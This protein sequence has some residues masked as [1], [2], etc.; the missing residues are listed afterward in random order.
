M[1]VFKLIKGFENYSVSNLGNVKN[2]IK[3]KILK[4]S[5]SHGYLNVCINGKNKLVHRLVAESFIPNPENKPCV[6][7]INNIRDDN[8]IENLRLATNKENSQN[9]S[10]SSNQELK[11]LIGIKDIIDG[12]QQYLKMG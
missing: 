1:E 11:G 2:N 6:D 4:Q 5:N 12:E 3:N 8:R 7:H 10:I 9:T